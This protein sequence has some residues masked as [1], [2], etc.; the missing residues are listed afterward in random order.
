[1]FYSVDWFRAKAG[2]MSRDEFR[3]HFPSA[4]LVTHRILGGRLKTMRREVAWP[5]KDANKK[6]ITLMHI[7]PTVELDPN[8]F[9][10]MAD[11]PF[12]DNFCLQIRKSDVEAPG[13]TDPPGNPTRSIK[14]GR[15]ASSDVV[16]NDYTVSK[17]HAWFLIDPIRDHYWVSDVG[18]TNGT[19]VDN[20]RLLAG[21]RAFIRS[22]QLVTF[23]RMVF[24][25]Y[26]CADFYD[27]L[28]MHSGRTVEAEV[29]SRRQQG[30]G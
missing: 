13:E 21:K 24:T 16:I 10:L 4:V 9:E 2:A 1:M 17:R 8:D 25:F 3:T 22:R 6:A 15:F 20:V 14:V 29:V 26:T 30:D 23:G 12:T 5:K 27:H 18:S 28:L 7:P 19:R 11:R